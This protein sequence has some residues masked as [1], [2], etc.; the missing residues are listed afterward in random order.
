MGVAEKRETQ[1][2]RKGS[3]L[4][5]T[6]RNYSGIPRTANKTNEYE[7]EKGEMTSKGGHPI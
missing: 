5:N 3:R 6:T 1:S 7:H 4:F 2:C